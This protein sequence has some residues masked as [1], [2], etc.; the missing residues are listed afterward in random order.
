MT[1]AAHSQ[2]MPK[3]LTIYKFFDPSV[4]VSSM[5][6]TTTDLEKLHRST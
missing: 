5:R 6:R 4:H 3:A 1:R 2:E